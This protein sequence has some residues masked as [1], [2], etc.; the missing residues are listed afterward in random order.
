MSDQAI[1][2]GIENTFYHAG[3]IAQESAGSWFANPHVLMRPRLFI[4]GN[5]WCALYGENIQDG[6]AGFGDSPADAVAD[7]NRAWWEKLPDKH[8]QGAQDAVREEQEA[9]GE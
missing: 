7:F 9:R 2:Q 5:Q 4:D 1:Q 3:Q 6:V 8:T